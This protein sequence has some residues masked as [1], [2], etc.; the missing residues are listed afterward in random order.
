MTRVIGYIR[1]STVHQADGGV[2]LEAQRRKLEQ[3]AELYELE[4]VAV[5]VD[6]GVS[7]KTLRR[8]ALQRALAALDAGEAEGLLIAKLDRLTR[9]VR[10]LGTLVETYFA[11]R[12]SLLSVADS[13]DTRTAG[14]RLVL[15]V[16]A[17]VSQWEREAASERTTE[18]L[19]HIKEEEG[20]TLG[21][22]ALGWQRTD[23]LDE[24]GRRVVQ[25]V[26]AEAEIVQRIRELRQRG[27]TLKAIAEQL[28]I[29]GRPTKRGGGWYPSTV[30]AVLQRAA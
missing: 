5:E 15:N 24:H 19:R 28:T 20:A 22:E 8:P 17:S 6:A 11:E 3:Y 25:R 23:E 4:L 21:G 13:I 18:V 30:R 16:L 1:V 29:E 27:A 10:D 2:S 7:A 9:S 26:D 14:G 12:Y